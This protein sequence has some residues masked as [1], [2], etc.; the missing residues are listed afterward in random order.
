MAEDKPTRWVPSSL[1]L[2]LI[3]WA[4]VLLAAAVAFRRA[5]LLVLGLPFIVLSTWSIATRP[6]SRPTV[7]HGLERTTPTEAERTRLIVEA[8]GLDGAESWTVQTDRTARVRW[9][10]SVTSA[11]A[12]VHRIELTWWPSRTGP[13][14]VGG[15]HV[16]FSSPWGAYRFGALHLPPLE[17]R[18]LPRAEAFDSRTPVP[19]PIGLVGLHRSSR[20]G[21]GTEFADVREFRPGDRLRSVH[22]PLTARTGTLHSRTNY[23]EQDAEVHLVVDASVDF[24]DRSRGTTIDTGL[25]AAAGISEF[26]LRQGDR[27]GLRVVGSERPLNLRPSLGLQHHRRVLD[28]LSAVNPGRLGDRD[29][30]GLRWNIPSGATVVM[31]S[32]L[33]GQF[34]STVAATLAARGLTIVVV[35]TLPTEP[36][37]AVQDPGHLIAMRIR[38]LERQMEIDALRRRGVPVVAWHGP[39]TLDDVMRR[40]ARRPPARAAAR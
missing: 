27:V 18:A 33:L 35:D 16:Q 14:W 1:L 12:D 2:Q 34:A 11:L 40:L 7:R 22:W 15:V 26:F 17:A 32:P 28:L 36:L 23:A 25:R 21:S 5:D 8:R 9:D 39:G 29:A 4:G 30:S 10:K 13:V 6:R 19:H 3:L 37:D 31:M 24:G 38:L 20:P